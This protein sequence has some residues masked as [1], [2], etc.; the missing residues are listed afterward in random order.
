MVKGGACPKSGV[1]MCVWHDISYPHPVAILDMWDMS[2]LYEIDGVYY[3]RCCDIL[4]WIR[5]FDGLEYFCC[6]VCGVERVLGK[7]DGMIEEM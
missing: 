6:S 4:R 3:Y 5:D 2:G 1:G 7:V